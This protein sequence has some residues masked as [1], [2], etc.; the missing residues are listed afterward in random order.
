MALSNK[1]SGHLLALTLLSGS[2][3]PLDIDVPDPLPTQYT[4]TGKL[5]NVDTVLNIDDTAR[6]IDLNQTDASGSGT[7]SLSLIEKD[8]ETNA[9][10]TEGCIKIGKHQNN[11]TPHQSL[12]SFSKVD[13][14]TLLW[15]YDNPDFPMVVEVA[16]IKTGSIVKHLWTTS[17]CKDSTLTSITDPSYYRGNKSYKVKSGAPE[18]E[19]HHGSGIKMTINELQAA[20]ITCAIDKN[21]IANPKEWAKGN[22]G[23]HCGARPHGPKGKYLSPLDY[24]CYLHDQEN[25]DACGLKHSLQCYTIHTNPVGPMSDLIFMQAQNGMRM[26]F[27]KRQSGKGKCPSAKDHF[28]GCK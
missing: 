8:G 21:C 24:S 20:L 17:S 3:F 11:A 27:V 5:G 16:S 19:K 1:I 14:G 4:I 23:W 13:D 26:L 22:Y 7:S 15:S 25:Y 28:D 18:K 2:A 10:S 12:G 6:Q 9:F